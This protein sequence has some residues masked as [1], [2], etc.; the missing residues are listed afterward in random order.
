MNIDKLKMLYG[1]SIKR[2]FI[3]NDKIYVAKTS[4]GNLVIVDDYVVNIGELYVTYKG[5]DTDNLL[6][7]RQDWVGK[8]A[9]IINLDNRRILKAGIVYVVQSVNDYKVRNFV[10]ADKN[11]VSIYNTDLKKIDRYSAKDTVTDLY[12]CLTDDVMLVQIFE[13]R[14]MEETEIKV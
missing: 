5:G 1:N 2:R 4:S 14:Y 10:T 11:K 12:C 9:I 3:D 8:D 13:G 7:C 6:I